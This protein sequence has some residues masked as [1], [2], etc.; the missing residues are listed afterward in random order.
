ME[1]EELARSMRDRN[2][3]DAKAAAEELG[4]KLLLHEETEYAKGVLEES[5]LDE[6]LPHSCF[7]QALE[8]TVNRGGIIPGSLF[9]LTC[10]AELA[11]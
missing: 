8:E 4:S 2:I 1:L 5:G 10:V 9:F 7:Q 3:G 11:V 6:M